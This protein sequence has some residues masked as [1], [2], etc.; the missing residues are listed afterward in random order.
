MTLE[1]RDE[2]FEKFREIKEKYVDQTRIWY[3]R[4]W[5]M[6]WL[7]F[8]GTGICVIVLSLSI[9]FLT[10]AGDLVPFWSVSVSALGIAVLTALN[11]FFAWQA[12]WE[13]RIRLWRTLESLSATWEARV[14]AA[15]AISDKEAA[16]KKALDATLSLIEET[17]KLDVGEAEALFAKINFP[18]GFGNKQSNNPA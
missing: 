15:R 16:R 4:N 17:G 9:P 8:R 18:E 2:S 1:A 5:K 6:P 13:K 11:T 14:E 10:A 3:E 7:L 12:T